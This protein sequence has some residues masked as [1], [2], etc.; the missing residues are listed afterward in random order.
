MIKSTVVTFALATFVASGALAS[1]DKTYTLSKDKTVTSVSQPFVHYSP[2]SAPP[3]GVSVIFGNVG[4]LYPKGLYFCCY[5][6]TI[7]GSGAG[8]GVLLPPRCSSHLPAI[9]K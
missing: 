9:P 1:S 8:V 5:G 3:K 6:N 7:S 4:T 2:A